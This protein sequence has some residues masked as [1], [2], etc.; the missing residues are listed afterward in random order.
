[1]TV[2]W[3]QCGV[4]D[5]K[6][7]WFHLI[8]LTWID[9]NILLNKQLMQSVIMINIQYHQTHWLSY[10]VSAREEGDC[11]KLTRKLYNK[12]SLHPIISDKIFSI[13]ELVYRSFFIRRFQQTIKD[14]KYRYKKDFFQKRNLWESLEINKS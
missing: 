1:M 5:W 10:N 8:F 9:L 11:I 2:I 14:C 4:K 6:R 3:F 12:P 7:A 13:I